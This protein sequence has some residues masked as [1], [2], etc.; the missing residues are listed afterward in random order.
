MSPLQYQKHLRLQEARRL[1]W[2]RHLMPRPRVIVWDTR[3][4]VSSAASN[5]PACSAH[6]P[7]PMCGDYAQ[8][9]SSVVGGAASLQC[10]HLLAKFWPNVRV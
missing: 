7:A 3:A 10:G 2:P 6:H 4:L 9:F 8:R 5:R 1:L